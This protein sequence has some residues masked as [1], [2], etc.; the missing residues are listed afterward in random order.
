MNS[1]S[2]RGVVISRLHCVWVLDGHLLWIYRLCA[3]FTFAF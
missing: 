3:Q 1:T 2:L